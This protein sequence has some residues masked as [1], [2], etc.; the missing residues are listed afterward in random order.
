[1]NH[2]PD[3]TREFS[4]LN[5]PRLEERGVTMSLRQVFALISG[6]IIVTSTVLGGVTA[7][8]IFMARMDRVEAIC[9]QTQR[10]IQAIEHKLSMPTKMGPYRDGEDLETMA[11]PSSTPMAEG[12]HAG[13]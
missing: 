11:E 6:V 9:L 3:K 2:D 1:M 10:S 4:P 13:P 5:I 7:C 8:R 12:P